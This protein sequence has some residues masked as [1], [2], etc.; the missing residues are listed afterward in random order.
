MTSQKI[1]PAPPGGKR[2]IRAPEFRRRLGDISEATLWRLQRGDVRFPPPG[3]IRHGH[4]RVWTE[5]QANA[6][7]EVLASDIDGA[8]EDAA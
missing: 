7:A 6:Y 2:L 8:D 4:V 1:P 5:E 3:R